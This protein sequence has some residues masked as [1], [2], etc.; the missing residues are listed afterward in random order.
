MRK[1][2]KH[3]PSKQV[4]VGVRVHP[5][6]LE[7]WR[8]RAR[9]L[10]LSVPMWLRGLANGLGSEA[11]AL[12]PFEELVEAVKVTGESLHLPDDAPIVLPGPD[13]VSVGGDGADWATLSKPLTFEEVSAAWID[14]CRESLGE[15]VPEVVV[16]PIPRYC[17]RIALQIT[18]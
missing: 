8:I 3:Y 9:G 2:R 12:P 16:P 7:V 4:M 5:S 18:P 11:P 13:V 1:K 14:A 17:P 10:G 15:P 6:E